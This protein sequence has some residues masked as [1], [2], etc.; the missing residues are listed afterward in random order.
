MSY[1]ER[2]DSRG[3]EFLSWKRKPNWLGPRAKSF[4]ASYTTHENRSERNERFESIVFRSRLTNSSLLVAKSTAVSSM[5]SPTRRE[6]LGPSWI[7]WAGP[8]RRKNLWVSTRFRR[9]GDLE[10]LESRSW[11]MFSPPLPSL[12]FFFVPWERC[13]FWRG[14]ERIN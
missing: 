1:L 6:K 13:F 10:H 5:E 9:Y 14:F 7:S 11:T 8:R 12:F 2:R 3:R 4:S